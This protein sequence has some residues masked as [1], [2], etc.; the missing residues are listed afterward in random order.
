[1][2]LTVGLVGQGWASVSRDTPG[3]VQGTAVAQEGCPE[4]L[5]HT[6]L[7]QAVRVALPSLP[8]TSPAVPEPAGVSPRLRRWCRLP[9]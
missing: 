4:D 9:T 5:P 3:W 6:A 7:S 2:A 8:I 1:M